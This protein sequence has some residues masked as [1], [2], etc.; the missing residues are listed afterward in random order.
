LKIESAKLSRLLKKV[1]LGGVISEVVVDLGPN[2]IQAV[3]PTNSIFISVAEESSPDGIGKIGIG[4]PTLAMLIKH[5]DAV[6]GE[7]AIKKDGKRLV[8]AALGRG[9]IKYLTVEEEF[10][11]SV[12]VEESNIEATIDPCVIFLDITQQACAD[13]NSYMSLLKTKSA[14]FCFTAKT[15]QVHVESGLE[16]EHQ[17]N[18]PFGKA[19]FVGEPW[20]EDFSVIV[21]GNHINQIFNTLEFPEKVKPQILMG[22]EHA[23]VVLQNDSNMWACLPLGE[24]AE[25]QN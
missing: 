5:L 21:Y 4:D 24:N 10:V 13:F 18:I 9:E 12:I 17:F 19:D 20:K 14:K 23:L 15:M 1:H 2:T 7:V 11:A 6:K 25:T 22:P 8:V 16:S 3:D